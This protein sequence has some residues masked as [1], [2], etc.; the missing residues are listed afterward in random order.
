[1]NKIISTDD[2]VFMS[3]VG[4]S[5]CGKSELIMQMLTNGT[6]QPSYD[7]ILYFYQEYQ[8]LY[9]DMVDKIPNIEF[10]KGIDFELIS[11]LENNGT[12]YLLIF[13]DS[14][15]EISKSRQFEKIATSGR[16]RKLNV[17]Y[18]KHN[19]FHKSSL[20]RDIELQNTHIVLFKSPRDVHQISKFGQQL[21]LAKHFT[22]WYKEA[23]SKPFGHLLIDLSPRT[24]DNLRFCANI[25][26]FPTEFFI[27]PAQARSTVL[28]DSHTKRIY[29]QGLPDFFAQ[30]PKDIS[31]TVSKKFHSFPLRVRGKRLGRKIKDIKNQIRKF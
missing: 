24:V 10:I 31:P 3:L 22:D 18:I 17:I 12:N 13:D 16:H 30:L 26:S 19:L 25:T 8:L 14:C 21:G 29:S 28:D 23:T 5:G 6:F 9:S 4:P 2:R 20:G 15:P 7:K 27:P 11:G 1:M